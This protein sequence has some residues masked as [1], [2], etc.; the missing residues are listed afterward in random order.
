MAMAAAGATGAAVGEAG[1]GGL[2]AVTALASSEQ[3][4]NCSNFFFSVV[5]IKFFLFSYF[6]QLSHL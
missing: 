4:I 1:A 3:A 6:L 2:Q 5:F